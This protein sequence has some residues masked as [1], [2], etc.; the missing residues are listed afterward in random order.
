MGLA[1][2]TWI[3]LFEGLNPTVV[4]RRM[5]GI[6]SSF[7][8]LSIPLFSMIGILAERCGMLPDLVKWL[9]ML[10]GRLKGGMAYIN[11]ANSLVMGG[12]SGAAVSDVASLGR[13]EIQMM[14]RAGYPAA[15]AA[16]L[17]ASTA[18]ISP[19][20]PPSIAMIIFGL[21]VGNISIGALFMAGVVPGVIMGLGL[22]IMAWFKSRKAGFGHVMDRPPL[23]VIFRQTLRV[24]PFMFL[25]LIIVGGIIGGVF[26]VTESAA[27]GICY[28]LFVGFVVTGTLR[29]RDFY[30]SIIYS[31]IIS[32]IVGMLMGAGAIV[33]WIIIRNQITQQL[34]D[35]L[36]TITSDPTM[37]MVLVALSVLALG[38]VAP[39]LVPIARHYGI[40]DIQFGVVFV[41]SCMIGMVTPPTGI[42][43]FMTSALGRVPIEDVF[44]AIL[45]FVVAAMVLIGLLIFYPPLTLYVPHVL[46]LL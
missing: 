5:Y 2:S 17:T 26:T 7:P 25:P 3:M 37:F 27:V 30:D 21:A 45:P 15:Y 36:V 13:I 23:H 1:G 33:S 6:M 31:A 29:L 35:F 12:V 44:K 28:L 14:K 24:V 16:A 8:L 9:Q 41:M 4:I 39:L 40:N 38:T 18:V 46:G 20:I 11:V 42:L 10:L 22:W 34:A 32:S 43:L 19:I